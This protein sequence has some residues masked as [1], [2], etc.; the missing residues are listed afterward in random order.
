MRKNHLVAV[1]CLGLLGVVAYGVVYPYVRGAF[2]W[3]QAEAALANRDFTQA[4]THL[5]RYRELWPQNGEACFLLARTCR[6]AGDAAAARQHLQEAQ[7]WQWPR[8]LIELEELLIQAQSAGGRSIHGNLQGILDVHP[9]DEP[10]IL[11]ALAIGCLVN[12]A[13][14]EAEHWAQVWHERYPDDWQAR[15]WRGVALAGSL[16]DK[17]AAEE[18][19]HVANMKPDFAEV[20]LRLTA[21]LLKQ[22]R[23]QEALPHL[24]H[25]L[26]TDPGHAGALLDLARCQR[27][28]GDR[29]AARVT[30]DT[31]LARQSGD[32]RVLLLRGQLALD[33]DK[34]GEALVWL[35]RAQAGAPHETDTNQVLAT[36]LRLLNKNDEAE[37]YA[38]AAQQIKQ[39]LQRVVD[40]T[41]EIRASPDNVALRHEAGTIMMRLGQEQGAAHML[42][43][44]LILDRNHQPTQK[45]LA[46]CLRKEDELTEED[47]LAA[48]AEW[49]AR[50]FFAGETDFPV[51]LAGY[52]QALA[53]AATRANPPFFPPPGFQPQLSPRKRLT[54]WRH[55]HQYPQIDGAWSWL[56]EMHDRATGGIPP[57]TE[58]EFAE[59]AHWFQANDTRLV[60]AA[61]PSQFV[62]LGEGGRI[63]CADI[64]AGITKGARVR[65]AGKLAEN[66]RRLRA[67]H[68]A[69]ELATKSFTAVP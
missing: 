56:A 26:R 6:R 1:V 24:Q 23:Y 48:F 28:C 18:F 65:G 29:N 22:G 9:P 10:Y 60:Q 37:R 12:Q 41:H 5:Q 31:L 4:Q 3:R 66:L 15:Y 30:L 35:R 52:R 36:V 2:A 47:L 16:R 40:L 25:Y 21:V 27:F 14:Q 49:G 58:A 57:V 8:P 19:A 61:L 39:D 32:A 62:D 55:T 20:R 33:D 69:P 13:P 68:A 63:A 17:L 50:G 59:L 53:A 7:R 42:L 54:Q 64:R 46:A 43:S 11:E 45:A 38:Q 67:R 44:A 51:A 34:P